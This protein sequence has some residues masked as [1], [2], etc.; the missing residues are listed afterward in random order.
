MQTMFLTLKRKFEKN[1]WAYLKNAL[2]KLVLK[3]QMKYRNLPIL[4]LWKSTA[5]TVHSIIVADLFNCEG[6]VPVMHNI[7]KS[8]IKD[9]FWS[10]LICSSQSKKIGQPHEMDKGQ[11]YIYRSVGRQT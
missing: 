11:T 3:L 7:V 8:K 9:T 2:R 6:A 5:P 1:G 4:D 10:F